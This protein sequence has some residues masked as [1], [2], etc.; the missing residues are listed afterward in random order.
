[1]WV[2]RLPYR[3]GFRNPWECDKILD[4]T[5]NMVIELLNYLSKQVLTTCTLTCM[6][7]QTLSYMQFEL[8]ELAEVREDLTV[9]KWWT[10][11]WRARPVLSLQFVAP[12]CW[13]MSSTVSEWRPFFNIVCFQCQQLSGSCKHNRKVPNYQTKLTNITRA[14]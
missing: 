2:K 6:S 14:P 7:F 13:L 4:N 8:C 1:M 9:R 11:G 10:I 5:L 12:P 3:K